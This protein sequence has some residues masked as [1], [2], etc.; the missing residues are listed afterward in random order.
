[1]C[2]EKKKKKPYVLDPISINCVWDLE[3]SWNHRVCHPVSVCTRTYKS[4][5][6][7]LMNHSWR[8]SYRR[9]PKVLEALRW[10]KT[11]HLLGY[12]ESNIKG[13][14][15]RLYKNFFYNRLLLGIGCPQSDFLFQE[16]LRKFSILSPNPYVFIIFFYYFLDYGDLL[17]WLRWFVDSRHN[18]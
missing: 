13:F 9:I 5:R 2:S 8:R 3:F 10:K 7:A 1:M 6:L 15:S 14:V 16:V 11:C 18:L 17:S 4:F 12:I